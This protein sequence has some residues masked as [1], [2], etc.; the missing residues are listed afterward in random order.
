MPSNVNPYNINGQY[1]IA[2]QDNDSQGF[3]DN[4]TNIRTNLAFAKAEIEDLQNKSM[5]KSPLEGGTVDNNFNNTL[6]YNAKV[7]QF[8]EVALDQGLL[9]GAIT[10]PYPNGHFQK[11]TTDGAVTL[12]IIN[13]AAGG[14]HAKL[15]LQI[16]VSDY[17][18]HTIQFPTGTII[19]ADE[20]A[21]AD[22]TSGEY[23]LTVP[24]N[25]DYVFDF[26]TSDGGNTVIVSEFTRKLVKASSI[27]NDSNFAT[28]T[29]VDNAVSAVLDSAPGT[30]DT[31]KELATAIGDDPAFFQTV[32]AKANSAD[33]AAVATSGAYS[34]LTG[35]PTIPAA[36]VN[37][38]WTAVSGVAEILN[39]PTIPAAQV[40]SD[41]TAVSGVA[42]I[43]NKPTL[44][45]VA[46]S[47]NYND[48]LNIP[49][50][51]GTQSVDIGIT[52]DS[53]GMMK[54]DSSFLYVCTANYDGVTAIWKKVA[55]SVL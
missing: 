35:A 6:V 40:N 3:R 12:Q 47:G 34:D 32:A 55:L 5:L 24:A 33:L 16:T 7:K 50:S 2:G 21:G 41:W 48:L 42:E 14:V 45:S 25:G 38:D 49:V 54:I 51:V 22:N 4:F 8:N 36:Q 19:G 27:V 39:K 44:A 1:P 43:L 53:A 11:F 17:T 26:S 28:E 15:R 52:G 37:S 46:T 23:V 18:T 29:Y 30:L 20:I 13:W 10:I 31:L 9:S